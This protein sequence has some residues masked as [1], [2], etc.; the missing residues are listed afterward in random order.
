MQL[1]IEAAL[2]AVAGIVSG[3][4][5]LLLGALACVASA[6]APAEWMADTMDQVLNDKLIYARLTLVDPFDGLKKEITTGQNKN[7]IDIYKNVL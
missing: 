4:G 1:D 5:V 6:S 3:I 7:F 2:A